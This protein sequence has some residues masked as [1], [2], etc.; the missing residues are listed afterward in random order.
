MLI[1]Y[2]DDVYIDS[3]LNIKSPDETY[4]H[5]TFPWGATGSSWGPMPGGND[6]TYN[7]NPYEYY[8]LKIYYKEGYWAQGFTGATLAQIILPNTFVTCSTSTGL[9]N[10]GESR[11]FGTV[12]EIPKLFGF[13]KT[14]WGLY[15]TIRAINANNA[16]WQRIPATG[17]NAYYG[18]STFYAETTIPN[19]FRATRLLSDGLTS[20]TQISTPNNAILSGWYLPSHDEM[21]FIAANTTNTFGYNINQNLVVNGE[22]LNGTYWTSTGAFNFAKLEG[23][24]GEFI[25]N[26]VKTQINSSPGSVAIAMNIDVNGD[27]NNYKVYKASRQD[28][29]KVRPVRMLRCDGLIPVS[30]KLWYIPPVY[31]DRI[32]NKNQTINNTTTP[33]LPGSAL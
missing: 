1:V 8:S 10:G 23:C 18:Y 13:W 5:N 28:L 30:S 17:Y 33:T 2:P 27:I 32:V 21:A 6:I 22:P 12:S 16:Y 31:K 15:N 24:Y 4:Q 11:A 25:I 9:G 20:D 26:G 19:A 7:D 14:S 3:K 29:Y